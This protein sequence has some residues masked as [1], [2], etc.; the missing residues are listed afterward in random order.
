MKQRIPKE[1]IEHARRLFAER[2]II[3]SPDRVQESLRNLGKV[4]AELQKGGHLLANASGEPVFCCRCG[5]PIFSTE[6][7]GADKG[8]TGVSYFFCETCASAGGEV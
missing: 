8:G 2:G 4:F 7:Y 1:L 3:L 5:S 6:G